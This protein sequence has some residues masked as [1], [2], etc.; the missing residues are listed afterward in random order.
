MARSTSVPTLVRAEC[1][2]HDDHCRAA[3][4]QFAAQLTLDAFVEAAYDGKLLEYFI[5]FSEQELQDA[6]SVCDN[7]NIMSYALDAMGL[8]GEYGKR[9]S[10]SGGYYAWRRKAYNPEAMREAVPRVDVEKAIKAHKP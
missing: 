9:F 1:D 4:C 7:E 2:R 10:W 3:T 6:W 5:R 8:W